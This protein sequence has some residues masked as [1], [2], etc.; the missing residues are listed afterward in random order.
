MSPRRTRAILSCS[1]IMGRRTETASTMM[2]A[3]QMTK[4]T[5]GGDGDDDV[6]LA[7]ASDSETSTNSNSPFS[8][9]AAI[10]RTA[11]SAQL[12]CRLR[13]TESSRRL[14]GPAGSLLAMHCAAQS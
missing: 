11:L 4:R 1:S 7:C 5:G 10:G 13:V 8:S 6:A 3:T 9:T 14:R 2:T 12:M